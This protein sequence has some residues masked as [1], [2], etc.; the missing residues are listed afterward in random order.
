MSWLVQ[1]LLL[2]F[3]LAPDA[4]SVALDPRDDAG[5]RRL[6][7]VSLLG[8]SID[9]IS[10][11]LSALQRRYMHATP[12]WGLDRTL[13]KFAAER[14]AASGKFRGATVEVLQVADVEAISRRDRRRPVDPAKLARYARD[15]GYDAV[16]AILPEESLVHPEAVA[17]VSIRQGQILGGSISSACVALALR[18]LRTD[19]GAEI[20]HATPVPCAVHASPIA[21]HAS[22]DDY[23]LEQASATLQVLR[24]HAVLTTGYALDEVGL[25]PRYRPGHR[26]VP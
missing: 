21:W 20:A 14:I 26:V 9:G 5:I 12:E 4:R 23:S 17:G 25:R 6:A 7:V 3:P 22:W 1:A 16:L 15:R 13:G 19:S 10:D 18:V 24:R 11:G 2:T 8:D